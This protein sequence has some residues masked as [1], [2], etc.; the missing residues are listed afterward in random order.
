MYT[1]DCLHFYAIHFDFLGKEECVHLKQ[2]DPDDPVV[3]VV[4]NV[5]EPMK[6]LVVGMYNGDIILWQYEKKAVVRKYA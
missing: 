4:M 2:G 6:S 5:S 1:V 3:P